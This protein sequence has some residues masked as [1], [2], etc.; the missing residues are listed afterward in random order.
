MKNNIC[1]YLTNFQVG[2]HYDMPF[3]NRHD[4]FLFAFDLIF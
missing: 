1:S 4:A 2:N 3:V